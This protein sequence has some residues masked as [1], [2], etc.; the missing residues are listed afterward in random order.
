MLATTLALSGVAFG[1]T[2]ALAAGVGD[3]VGSEATR[4]SSAWGVATV[5]WLGQIPLHLLAIALLGNGFDTSTIGPGALAGIAGAAGGVFLFTGLSRGNVALVAGISAILASLTAV[6][7]DATRS[8]ALPL[9]AWVGVALAFP[10]IFFVV[11]NGKLKDALPRGIGAGVGAGISFGVFYVVLGTVGGL[12]KDPSVVLVNAG[13]A[14]ILLMMIAPFYRGAILPRGK[15]LAISLGSAL[16][17]G[18]HILLFILAVKFGSIATATVLISQY[19][20]F[21]VLMAIAFWRQHPSGRQVIGLVMALVAVGLIA[22][23]ST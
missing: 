7:W 18:L 8:V 12:E 11:G 1:I 19:P 2:S 20:A 5:T 16:L 17:S 13:T 10:A 6:A 3:F 15:A 21:T 14:G 9:S 23:G 4:R 22:S